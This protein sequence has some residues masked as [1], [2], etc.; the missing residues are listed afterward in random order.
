M[1]GATNLADNIDERVATL[2]ARTGE[3]MNQGNKIDQLMSLVNEVKTTIMALRYETM[4]KPECETRQAAFDKK[5]LDLKFETERK[6]TDMRKGQKQL[7]WA[8]VSFTVALILFLV[9]QVFQLSIKVG[10][11]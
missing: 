3:I 7:F 2:E 8:A 4:S 11:Q 9:Q 1:E 6:F 10:G 5:I